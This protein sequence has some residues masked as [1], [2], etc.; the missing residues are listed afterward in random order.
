MKFDLFDE[1]GIDGIWGPVSEA[2]ADQVFAYGELIALEVHDQP[3]A[4]GHGWLERGIVDPHFD[5]LVDVFGRG[6][7]GQAIGRQ[8]APAFAT[9][10]S[11]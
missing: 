7:I 5:A 4:V 11:E 1:H 2:D 10:R 3:A 8:A 9:I 6:V